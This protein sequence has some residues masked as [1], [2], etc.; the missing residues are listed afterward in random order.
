[1]SAELLLRVV[2]GRGAPPWLI[3]A[4]AL[5]E[6]QRRANTKATIFVFILYA[7]KHTH[8]NLLIDL[9]QG[10]FCLFLLKIH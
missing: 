3:C 4:T 2:K 9:S 6:R 5:P 8:N 1:L 10:G 7:R